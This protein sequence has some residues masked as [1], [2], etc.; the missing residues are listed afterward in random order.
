MRLDSKIILQRVDFRPALFDLHAV[1][2]TAPVQQE[3]RQIGK[4]GLL[5]RGSFIE[6]PPGEPGQRLVPRPPQLS[7]TLSAEKGHPDELMRRFPQADVLPDVPDWFENV[8]VESPRIAPG[9]GIREDQVQRL[10]P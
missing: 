6:R 2:R 5:G 4:I 8:Q 1:N 7:D 10:L 3:P 9:G